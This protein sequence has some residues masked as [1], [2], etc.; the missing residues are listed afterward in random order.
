M[1]D[2]IADWIRSPIIIII[3]MIDFVFHYLRGSRRF[4]RNDFNM[5]V[6]QRGGSA[7]TSVRRGVAEH[8]LPIVADEGSGRILRSLLFLSFLFCFVY[9]NSDAPCLIS[10][11]FFSCNCAIFYD[12]PFF[13]SIS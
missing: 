10:F 2:T 1:N 7:R 5:C 12:C 3:I 13:L 9:R 8:L 11:P 4:F 6:F